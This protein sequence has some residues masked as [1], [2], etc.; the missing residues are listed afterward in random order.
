MNRRQRKKYEKNYGF[1]LDMIHYCVNKGS[2]G[3]TCDGCSYPVIV[4]FRKLLK[5][6]GLSFYGWSLIEVPTKHVYIFQNEKKHKEISF[7]Y[8]GLSD[9]QICVFSFDK[10]DDIPVDG[11]TEALQHPS[12]HR[13]L[14]LWSHFGVT[15][16][17][18][19]RL[20]K[21]LRYVK[22]HHL[23]PWFVNKG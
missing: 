10:C 18:L 11:I 13:N 8:N 20:K 14:V 19:R 5:K 15:V 6:E 23:Q 3:D 4:C 22:K 7:H 9:Y 21:R 2:C 1:H 17:E 16:T 12:Q